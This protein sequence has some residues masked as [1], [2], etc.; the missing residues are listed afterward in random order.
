[1]TSGDPASPVSRAVNPATPWPDP[2]W[3]G[4][5]SALPGTRGKG[6]CGRRVTVLLVERGCVDAGSPCSWFLAVGVSWASRAAARPGR[7]VATLCPALLSITRGSSRCFCQSLW[8]SWSP[9][10][11]G[12]CQQPSDNVESLTGEGCGGRAEA[13]HTQSARHPWV[14]WQRAPSFWTPTA[15]PDTALMSIFQEG[16]GLGSREWRGCPCHAGPGRWSLTLPPWAFGL[17]ANS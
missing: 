3:T 7:L 13:V 6:L 4:A 8:S 12:R 17:K 11:C 10:G 1:M 16:G 14:H 15:P 2:A 5:A 9:W